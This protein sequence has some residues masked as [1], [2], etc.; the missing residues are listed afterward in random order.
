ME[1]KL[2]HLVEKGTSAVMVVQEAARQLEAAGFEELDFAAGWGLTENGRYYV[3]HHDTALFAFTIGTKAEFRNA[4]RIGAAHTDFPCLRIKP[5]PDI[6]AGGYGQVNVEVYGGAILNTWLD[7]PLGISGRVAVQSGDVL[8][9]DMRYFSAD[10]P[11]L[12]IPN[13][14]I[15]MN[16]EVN[17]GVELNKQTDML[18]ILGLL[19]EKI[20]DQKLLIEFLAKE[21]QTEPEQILDYELWVYC[22][23]KPQYVG[24]QEEFILSPRL[25]NLTSVQALLTGLIGGKRESG[26][27]VVALFDHEEVGSQTKQGAGSLLLLT[28]LEKINGSMKKTD[29]QTRQS[30][31]NAFF[32]SVDVAHG[33]HPNK[34]G[35]MDPTNKPVLGRGLCIKEAG[36]QSYATDCEAVA[37]VEQICRKY[38]VPYQKFVNR[39]DVRG[40]G[41]LGS[42]ASSILPVRT[43]DIGIPVLAMHS[44]AETMGT[45]DMKA[46]TKLL[47]AYFSDL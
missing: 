9:P 12:V 35:K 25:D 11:L 14:A 28:L 42:I 46:L 32:L 29:E 36:S 5:N 34:M 38:K 24:V 10:R 47:T 22:A 8:H 13:L 33:L 16:R 39:S 15:H 17:Q 27:N 2:F 3:K 37:V 1:D 19:D 7:R 40:G 41:T 18:P 20:K 31:Y 23:Q 21:L 26:L 4:V 43:V 45:A 6:S 30:L 44:A